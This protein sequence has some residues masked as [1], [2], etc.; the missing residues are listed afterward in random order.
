MNYSEDTDGFY[1]SLCKVL[2][3]KTTLNLCLCDKNEVCAMLEAEFRDS[4]VLSKVQIQFQRFEVLTFQNVHSIMLNWIT[5][6][7][8]LNKYLSIQL[9]AEIIVSYNLFKSKF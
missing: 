7:C 6:L 2:G 9:T 3:T 8:K 4:K 1:K 5:K